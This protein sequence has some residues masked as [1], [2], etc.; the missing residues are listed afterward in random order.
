MAKAT[1]QTTATG[2][3]K[4]KRATP[5][6]RATQAKAPAATATKKPAPKKAAAKKPAADKGASKKPAVKKTAVKK[7]AATKAKSA[8]A[9][10][11]KAKKAGEPVKSRKPATKAARA[12]APARVRR[13]RPA[14]VLEVSPAVIDTTSAAE[15]AAR[16]VVEG[17][18]VAPPAANPLGNIFEQPAA[19]VVQ[20]GSSALRH[21]KELLHRPVAA[22]LESVFGPAPVPA[23]AMRRFMQGGKLARVQRLRGSTNFHAAQPTVPH[24]SAGRANVHDQGE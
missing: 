9:A 24:R 16:L 8:A 13:V 23:E 22:Q 2:A 7:P 10:P 12:Q 17:S 4:K 15:V 1:G 19:P 21:V 3:A 14:G 20:R 18:G 11:V 6:A 5:K